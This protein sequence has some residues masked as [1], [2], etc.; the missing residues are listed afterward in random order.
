MTP[1]PI[2]SSFFG[3][4]SSSRAPVEE[5]TTFSSMV[6]P[7]RRATSEPVAITMFLVSSIWLP[8]S[9]AI[10]STRPAPA[11]RP[12]PW[13]VSILFFLSRNSTPLVLP[14]TPSALKAIIFFRSSFGVPTSMPRSAK[15]VLASS[16]ASEAWS[17]AFDGMQ[18]TLRQVPPWVARFST[19]AVCRPSCAAR[20]AQT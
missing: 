2:T 5:T 17:S 9:S 14:A 19:T 8:P 1:A 10:T 3:T 13:K 15:C 7:G 12:V 6:T 18:P 11:I 4:R 20:I 16:K